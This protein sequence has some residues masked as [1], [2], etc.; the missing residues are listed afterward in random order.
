MTP[1]VAS[2]SPRSAPPYALKPAVRRASKE[3][4]SLSKRNFMG[5][6]S[7]SA[8]QGRWQGVQLDEPERFRLVYWSHRSAAK[9]ETQPFRLG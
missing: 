2:T 9:G 5:V 1:A 8:E 6:A 3:K 7:R 4:D